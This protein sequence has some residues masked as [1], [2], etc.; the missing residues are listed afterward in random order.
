MR[1]VLT[2]L[3]IATLL[4]A[5]AIS[6]ANAGTA[7]RGDLRILQSWAQPTEGSQSSGH[8]TI[9]NDGLSTIALVGIDTPV[10]EKVV[11]TKAGRELDSVVVIGRDEVRFDGKPFA[12][13]LVGLS[14]PLAAGGDFPVTFRFADGTAVELRMAIGD[15]P[16][17]PETNRGPDLKPA[18][19][20]VPPGQVPVAL[21][22]W[23]QKG[24]DIGLL[25]R[26]GTATTADRQS[27]T[28]YVG[29]Y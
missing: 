27:A 20:Q 4:A 26:T 19:G 13:S 5:A 14:E 18:P 28:F 29:L 1:R 12:I 3:S 2:T 24:A 11:I 22:N 16:G 10:A 25:H 6:A 9:A 7:S 21:V 23:S 15:V 8:T 17:L